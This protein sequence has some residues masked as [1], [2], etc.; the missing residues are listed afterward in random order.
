M[1]KDAVSGNHKEDCVSQKAA[2][3]SLSVAG[4]LSSSA[5]SKEHLLED[6]EMQMPLVESHESCHKECNALSV[7]SNE[8]QVHDDKSSKLAE[9]FSDI[10]SKENAASVFE[11]GKAKTSIK[12]ARTIL[13][14]QMQMR[15]RFSTTF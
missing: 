12:K 9:T 3:A 14:M 8:D 15:Q 2:I 5:A 6:I 7:G 10:V 11:R 13:M 4:A 1:A